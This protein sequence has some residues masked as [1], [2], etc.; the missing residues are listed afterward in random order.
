[1]Q[2][3]TEATI[4]RYRIKITSMIVNSRNE[5]ISR[6]ERSDV[7]NCYPASILYRAD[8]SSNPFLIVLLAS[9][10][11][12]IFAVCG[13]FVWF[14]VKKRFF[15]TRET[16]SYL[17]SFNGSRGAKKPTKSLFSRR[18]NHNHNTK[19]EAQFFTHKQH[20][21]ATNSKSSYGEF[22]KVQFK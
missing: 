22:I 14:V 19:H 13:F 2:R 1:M 9:L 3:N 10:F 5:T 17:R 15:Y 18:K 21:Q 12:I 4:R 6:Y 20:A 7:V 11:V 8:T 16:S